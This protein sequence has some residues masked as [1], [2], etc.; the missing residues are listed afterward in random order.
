MDYDWKYF[1]DDL[2]DGKIDIELIA[3]HENVVKDVVGRLSKEKKQKVK[4]L[5]KGMFCNYRTQKTENCCIVEELMK[6][7]TK[8]CKANPE[9]EQLKRRHNTVVYRY[10][11]KTEFHKKAIAIKLDVSSGTIQNDISQ[12]MEEIII[13]CFG[14]RAQRSEPKSLYEVVKYLFRHYQLLKLSQEIETELIWKEWQQLRVESLEKTGRVI[15]YIEKA[16]QIYEA[17]IAGSS[18][19][20]M[21]KRALEV[22]KRI[23]LN[24][25]SSISEMAAV[26][27]VTESIIYSD[28]NKIEERFAELFEIMLQS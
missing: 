20:D 18:S 23:Y 24:G 25:N 9:N 10:M 3:I 5:I 27:Q 1:I 6:A 7:H 22:V 12:T 11:M 14:M 16:V 17:F 13:L 15:E 4:N 21:Q 2:K 8:Y 28:I 26:Y 19:P